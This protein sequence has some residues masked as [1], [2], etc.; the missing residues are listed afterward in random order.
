MRDMT[1]TR[2]RNA[3]RGMTKNSGVRFTATDR[4]C[5]RGWNAGRSP[6]EPPRLA[7]ISDLFMDRACGGPLLLYRLLEDYPP[8]RLLVVSIAE[9]EERRRDPVT[10]LPGANALPGVR[11]VGVSCPDLSPTEYRMWP[12][13]PVLLAALSSADLADT[14]TGARVCPRG[15]LDRGLRFL[16]AGGARAARELGI[17]LHLILYDD[18][19]SKVTGNREGRVGMMKRWVMR[20]VMG[21]VYR[22]ATSRLCVSPGMA[23]QYQEWFKTGS[24]VL[25]P[26]R[27]DDS[28]EP[29]L[30]VRHVG[31]GPPVVAFCGRIHQAGN[32]ALLRE[33]AAVLA[34]MNGRI[35]FYGPYTAQSLAVDY[36]LT[37]PVVRTAGFFPAAEMGERVG[38]TAHA[39]FLPASFEPRERDDVATLFPSKLADYTAIGLPVLVWGAAIARRHAGQPRILGRPS[40][41]PILTRMLSRPLSPSL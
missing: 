6:D 41:S 2:A 38:R 17:P 13:W 26:S 3:T 37:A 9:H 5:T 15:G 18:W 30:R 35:D 36:G 22:R 24:K 40:A 25:Y 32:A 1:R 31:D 7:I 10:G 11:H 19:A 39:L 12:T 33:L 28:P 29:R 23:E 21:P 16:L 4:G 34:T 14:R 8:D 27:G 20:Q